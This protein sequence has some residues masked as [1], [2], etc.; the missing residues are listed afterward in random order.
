M[1]FS[2]KGIINKGEQ[3]INDPIYHRVDDMHDS[4]GD[5]IKEVVDDHYD[6]VDPVDIDIKKG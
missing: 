1:I 4:D 3:N 6:S 2:I 5:G